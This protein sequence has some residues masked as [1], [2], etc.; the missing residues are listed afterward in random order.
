MT[1][2]LAPSAKRGI[3]VAISR[4]ASHLRSL[5]HPDGY[6]W[7]R[8][9]SN[10]TITAEVLLIHKIWGIDDR[11]PLGKIETYLR[12]QQRDHGG[13]ELYY[14]DGGELSTTIE[15]YLALRLLGAPLDDPA[16]VRARAFI[17]ARGGLSKAR[18]FTKLHLAV[19]GA[20]EWRGLPILP[21]WLMFIPPVVRFS[22]Y[23][24]SSWARGSTVPLVVVFD[25]QPQWTISPKFN[26]DELYAEGRENAR[27]A[28]TSD[29]DWWSKFFH[30]ADKVLRLMKQLNAVPFRRAGLDAAMRWFLERQEPTGDWAGIIPPMLNSLMALRAS[31]YSVEDEPVRKGF[32]ALRDFYVEDDE[33]FWCQPSISVIWDTALS[34]RA[35]ADAGVPSHDP[36]MQR[37]GEWLITKQ[38]ETGGDWCLRSKGAPGGWAFEFWNDCYPDVDDSSAVILALN[39]VRFE[40]DAT[41]VEAIRKG[42]AWID[43]MQ[44]S[45]GGW[46]AYDVDNTNDL[47]NKLPYGDLKALID[48]PTADLTAHCLEMHLVCGTARDARVIE[49]ATRFLL[50]EQEDDGS[51]FGRWGV[52]YLN[53]T[54]A[55]MCALAL[56]P[57]EPRVTSALELAQRWLIDVQNADGG[58]GETC[59]SYVRPSSKALGPSTPSQTAWAILGLL[60]MNGILSEAGQDAVDRGVEFLLARQ[61]SNGTWDEPQFTGT[62]F[63][64][65]FYLNYNLYRHHYVLSALGRYRRLNG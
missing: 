52:N 12:R 59:D 60:A 2:L 40:N 7:A 31:G 19:I 62:G 3:D 51:W 4:A 39:E 5:Q 23:D 33:T 1:T 17:L 22:I 15:A 55:A 49:R 6:W 9:E 56:L 8:L 26:V 16:L 14:D 18:V 35:L 42:A 27:F 34:M 36:A 50:D 43:S 25:R 65:H 47:L 37:A 29:D 13:W 41:R 10:A 48:P 54:G 57:P 44:S 53:G 20:Y 28:L 45:N 24:M 64:G 58:W 11:L 30:G 63:P 38:I 21:P 46:G 32:E 61:T